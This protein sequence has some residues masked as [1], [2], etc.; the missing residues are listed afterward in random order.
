MVP[1]TPTS[2]SDTGLSGGP[3]PERCG[4]SPSPRHSKFRSGSDGPSTRKFLRRLF[5]GAFNT[6]DLSNG[7]RPYLC[8]PQKRSGFLLVEGAGRKKKK[9]RT[10][11]QPLTFRRNR[12]R[13]A[14]RFEQSFRFEPVTSIK[15]SSHGHR[16]A[17][18]FRK[19]R[20]HWDQKSSEGEVPE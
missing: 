10:F 6:G 7:G 17:S 19:A 5:T 13:A 8:R 4:R 11:G 20:L 1:V 2:F 16:R 14:S 15:A 9:K 3:N 12:S 18:R